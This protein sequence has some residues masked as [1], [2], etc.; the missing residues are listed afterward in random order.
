[1]DA[2]L[3]QLS[4]TVEQ[5]ILASLS[6]KL[7]DFATLL[8][9]LPEMQEKKVTKAQILECWN[10][11]SAFKVSADAPAPAAGAPSQASPKETKA[12]AKTDKTV[13]CGIQLSRGERKGQ[14]CGKPCVIDTK[15]CPEHLK[16][17]MTSPKVSGGDALSSVAAPSATPAP[18]APA[19]KPAASGAC[20]HKLESGT[21]KGNLCGKKATKDT[22]CTVHAK[23]YA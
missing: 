4:K 18:A 1:M 6:T 14:A 21:N 7:N 12:R 19:A 2:F 8:V 3:E 22:W 9:E 20:Q 17:N 23:K 16:K 11:L 10:A 5:T 13:K 15:F